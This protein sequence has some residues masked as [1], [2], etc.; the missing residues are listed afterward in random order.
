MKALSGFPIWIVWS[1]NWLKVAIQHWLSVQ[2][3][4]P[5]AWVHSRPRWIL[6]SLPQLSFASF[7]VTHWDWVRA[8]YFLFLPRFL[9]SV[10]PALCF[11]FFTVER[12]YNLP[13]FE[14]DLPAYG[15]RV[16]F[17]HRA[18]TKCKPFAFPRLSQMPDLITMS[19]RYVVL[20]YRFLIVFKKVLIDAN[21]RC[22]CDW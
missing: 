22:I 14:N 2:T 19:L 10:N 12:M 5:I 7:R 17:T 11:S 13:P 20:R 18:E 15:W 9:L 8:S 3:F 6:S 1:I 21:Y 4:L 16:S